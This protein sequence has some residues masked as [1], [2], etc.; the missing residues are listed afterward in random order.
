MIFLKHVS[1]SGT[2][3]R[4]RLFIQ[5]NGTT[6]RGE[7]AGDQIEKCRFAAAGGSYNG[8][9]FAGHQVKG[10]MRKGRCLTGQC[11]IGKTHIPYFQDGIHGYCLLFVDNGIILSYV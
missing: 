4:Y 8:Q 5:S 9:K 3:G 6:F 11:V 1:Y 7:K 10:Y 2:A